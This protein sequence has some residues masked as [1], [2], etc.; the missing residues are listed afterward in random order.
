M[1]YPFKGSW[2]PRLLFQR[3]RSLLFPPPSS[4]PAIRCNTAFGKEMTCTTEPLKGINT[5]WEGKK[6]IFQYFLSQLYCWVVI[7][8]I[9]CS[10]QGTI[11]NMQGTETAFE[12]AL[13]FY[14]QFWDS[15]SHAYLYYGAE[16]LTTHFTRLDVCQWC[17]G[18]ANHSP[19]SFHSHFGHTPKPAYSLC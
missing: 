2:N 7:L 6:N 5:R 19:S 12:C 4:S 13:S 16:V 3:L 15:R 9:N 18:S 1:Y 8:Y 14:F 10:H 11:I 17:S